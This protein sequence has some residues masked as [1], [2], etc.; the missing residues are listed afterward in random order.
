MESPHACVDCNTYIE[1]WGGDCSKCTNDDCL[2]EECLCEPCAEERL[3]GA[4]PSCATGCHQCTGNS[5]NQTIEFFECDVEDCPMDCNY[6][7][8]DVNCDRCK[9]QL[10][11]EFGVD[12]TQKHATMTLECGHMTCFPLQIEN[13]LSRTEYECYTCVCIK[14]EKEATERRKE[15]AIRAEEKRK[16]AAVVAAAESIKVEEDRSMMTNLLP[17]LSSASAKLA[18]GN[19][20]KR[21]PRSSSPKESSSSNNKNNAKRRKTK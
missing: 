5:G 16:A 13:G 14:R 9:R 21:Y 7:E 3:E 6:Y 10:A 11:K 17:K 20:L 15:A 18:V 1:Y 2:D 12:V 4:C 19:W 8:N